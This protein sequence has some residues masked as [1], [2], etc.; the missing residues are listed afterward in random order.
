M[1]IYY[2]FVRTNNYHHSTLDLPHINTLPSDLSKQKKASIQL[3]NLDSL[4]Q[5]DK[6]ESE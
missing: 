4:N 2:R 1:V 3:K 6:M 5:G